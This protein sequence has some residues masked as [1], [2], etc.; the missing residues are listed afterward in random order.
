MAENQK[1]QADNKATEAKAQE[2]AK[3]VEK[4]TELTKTADHIWNTDSMVNSLTVKLRKI[5]GK[6]IE[7]ESTSGLRTNKDTGL[8]EAF[9]TVKLK[10]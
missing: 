3:K 2:K 9:V 10:K 4:P 5:H 8:E 6:D 7:V 1:A